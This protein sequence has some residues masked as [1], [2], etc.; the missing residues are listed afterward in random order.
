MNEGKQ[1]NYHVVGVAG[2]GMSALAQ[3][4]LAEGHNVSGSDRFHDQGDDLDVFRKLRRSGLNLV[5][6]DGSGLGPETSAVV[7][8]TAIEKDNAEMTR[9]AE[10]KVPV[11]HRA[12]MLACLAAGHHTIAVTGTS[13][14]T[15]VTGMIGWIMECLGLDPTVVNG[16]ALINWKSDFRIGN[17]RVGRSEHWVVE[18][19]ESDR[20]LLRFQPE[21]AVITNI[22]KDHF[23]LA[24]VRELF[25]KFAGQVKQGIVCGPGVAEVLRADRA[26]PLGVE[27][28]EE[29]F[30]PE[31]EDGFH[32]FW[33]KGL[34]FRCGLL[35][36]HNAE[37]AFAAVVLC[38]RLGLDLAAV[39]NA[40]V[41]FA[42]IERRLQRA[43]GARGVLVIDDYAHNPAKIRAAWSSLAPMHGRVLGVWRPHGFGPL[44]SM[45]SELTE[46]FCEVC[47][48]RDRVYLLPVFYA[49]GTA[50]GDVKSDDLAAI[51]RERGVGASVVR[52]YDE[53]LRALSAECRP[54]DC[55]L[56]MGARDPYLPVFSRRLVATLESL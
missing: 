46:T 40:L 20:S 51:L 17:V 13:G 53:L 30:V 12:E 10:L 18:A 26:K 39:R 16:G 5:R 22:S 48:P 54:G 9:A 19:D 24:E 8:S 55:V 47:R 11:M 52:D 42:G 25:R 32:N 36:R 33:Y 2:V 56:C 31:I 1:K 49:G 27:L 43:G 50:G 29:P 37:N 44:K 23:E 7:V 45:M 15:T 28:I 35:G 21:W 14:K 3:I 38:D 4:L 34:T 41:G 6:Q